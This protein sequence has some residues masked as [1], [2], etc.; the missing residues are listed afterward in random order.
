VAQVTP[1]FNAAFV[2]RSPLNGKKMLAVKKH[3]ESIIL[4]RPRRLVLGFHAQNETP[5]GQIHCGRSMKK[6]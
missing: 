3:R 6:Y 2:A 4:V 5:R 1:A